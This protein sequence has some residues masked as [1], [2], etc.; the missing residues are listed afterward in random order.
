MVKA[1]RPSSPIIKQLTINLISNRM[2]M[3]KATGL[4]T[5]CEL[6][7]AVTEVYND[8]LQSA[9]PDPTSD[10][11]MAQWAIGGVGGIQL[12]HLTLLRVEQVSQGS[13]Q[14]DVRLTH[15]LRETT[16]NNRRNYA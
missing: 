7:M 6:A 8:F 5:T 12:E 4:L 16:N 2:T 10:P 1:V 3:R 11:S 15:E 13:W 14:A 9:C